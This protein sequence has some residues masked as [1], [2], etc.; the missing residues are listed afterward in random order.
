MADARQ[1]PQKSAARTLSGYLKFY[2]SALE[3]DRNCVCAVVCAELLENVADVAFHRIFP[4]RKLRRNLLVCISLCDQHWSHRAG[5]DVDRGDQ[6]L[7]LAQG[8]RCDRDND[9][10]RIFSH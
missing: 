7:P 8:T 10:V 5:R 2:D 9:A 6:E 1:N 4:N 3:C